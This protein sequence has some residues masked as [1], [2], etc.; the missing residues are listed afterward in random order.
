MKYLNL[1]SGNLTIN[2]QLVRAKLAGIKLLFS[3]PHMGIS[4][5]ISNNFAS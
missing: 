2:K 3:V 5:E 1:K 4:T